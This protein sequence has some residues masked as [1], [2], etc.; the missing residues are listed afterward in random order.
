MI[1]FSSGFYL[2]GNK[3]YASGFTLEEVKNIC[4]NFDIV[5]YFMFYVNHSSIVFKWLL[6]LG[7][8]MSCVSETIQQIKLLFSKI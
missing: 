2:S 6:M 7:T 5:T 4:R 3:L 8:V 1:Y